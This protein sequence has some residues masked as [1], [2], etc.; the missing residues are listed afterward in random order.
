MPLEIVAKSLRPR[1]M[2]HE[3]P[4]LGKVSI[5]LSASIEMKYLPVGF[6]RMVALTILPA[7]SRDAA[8]R[9]SPS[10]G[11]LIRLSITAM[12]LL[13]NLLI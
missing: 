3:A 7:T 10:L 5:L 6:L 1:S 12:L 4:V 2:P 8:K 9:T 11:S 13:T